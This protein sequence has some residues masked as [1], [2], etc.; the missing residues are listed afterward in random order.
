MHGDGVVVAPCKQPLKDLKLDYLDL[1]LVHWPFPN[2][3]APGFDVNSHNS[4]SEPYHDEDYMK[5]WKQMEQLVA[6][7]LVRNIGTY[8]TTIPKIIYSYRMPK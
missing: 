2:Y 1:Y 6:M 5:V 4:D 3:H 7:R 8:N